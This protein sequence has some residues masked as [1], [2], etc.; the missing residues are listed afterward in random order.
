MLGGLIVEKPFKNEATP[1]DPIRWIIVVF[2]HIMLGG[3][4][5][6]K[7]FKNEATPSEEIDTNGRLR[8]GAVG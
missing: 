4:I 2:N 1:S 6:E 7:P 5:V 8:Q 3:L